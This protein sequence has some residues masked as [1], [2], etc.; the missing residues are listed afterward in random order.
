MY[1][2]LVERY[3]HKSEMVQK[4]ERPINGGLEEEKKDNI[5]EEKKGSWDIA[6]TLFNRRRV[7]QRRRKNTRMKL[8][9]EI[10]K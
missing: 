8:L 1:E 6:I 4:K 10:S 2:A 5:E 3:R 9:I 7:N